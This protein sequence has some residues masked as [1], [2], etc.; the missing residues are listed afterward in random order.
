VRRFREKQDNKQQ[1]VTETLQSVTET[2]PSA[3]ASASV[4]VSEEDSNITDDSGDSKNALF[5][6]F[7]TSYPRKT[8]KGAALKSWKKI[9]EPAKTLELILKS[10][11]WQKISEQ[12]SKDGGD[13]IPLPTTYLN[14]QRWLDEPVRIDP[15]AESHRREQMLRDRGLLPPLPDKGAAQ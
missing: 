11:E 14:Q 3:S 9:K 7:W 6:S 5:Q 8:G 1:N 15:Q 10:L 13:F 2:L 4:S 12:W